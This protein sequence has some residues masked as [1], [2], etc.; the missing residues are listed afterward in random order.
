MLRR[1]LEPQNLIP[2]KRNLELDVIGLHNQLGHEIYQILP[3]QPYTRYFSRSKALITVFSKA[4]KLGKWYSK[5][6]DRFRS[7]GSDK[8]CEPLNHTKIYYD[9][10][11]ITVFPFPVVFSMYW[12]LVD[13][14]FAGV[15]LQLGVLEATTI[16]SKSSFII[17]AP[18][19]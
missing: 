18:P 14:W 9:S 10:L 19:F 13:I 15:Y 3:I 7:I 1:N 11:D 16:C 8:K 4:F 6:Y 12:Q 5:D 2:T 17:S